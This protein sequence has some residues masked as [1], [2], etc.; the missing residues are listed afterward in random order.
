L[1]KVGRNDPC[2]CGSGNKFKKCC[3][4]PES[5]HG[6]EISQDVLET[7]QKMEKER[8]E[9]EAT[10]GRARAPVSASYRGYRFVAVG[11]SV[12]WFRESDVKTFPDFLRIYL[13]WCMGEKWRK[14]Q[15]QKPTG[16]QHPLAEWMRGMQ[17]QLAREAKGGGGVVQFVPVGPTLACALLSYDLYTVRDN[18]AFQRSVLDRLRHRDHFQSARYRV[19]CGCGVCPGR[20][21]DRVRRQQGRFHPSSGIRCCR[22]RDGGEADSRG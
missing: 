5:L 16:E 6:T 18:G 2:P 7:F 11:G 19:V 10:F 3:G 12:Q 21:E 14:E 1:K 4:K 8:Q 20:V 9:R 15:E 13:R 22:S 17:V